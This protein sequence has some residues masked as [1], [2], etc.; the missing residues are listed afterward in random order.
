MMGA[1]VSAPRSRI[2]AALLGA[3]GEKQMAFA[4]PYQRKA[5]KGSA[6]TQSRF[7]LVQYSSALRAILF[8]ICVG[9]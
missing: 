4:G 6:A 3:Q 5:W 9:N 7:M 1:V 2:R 8:R